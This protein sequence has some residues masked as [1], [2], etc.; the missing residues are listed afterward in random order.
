MVRASGDGQRSRWFPN[1]VRECLRG[2]LVIGLFSVVPQKWRG[3]VKESHPCDFG[4][5]TG[6]KL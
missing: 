1:S 3:G 6:V 5:I 2:S 4:L